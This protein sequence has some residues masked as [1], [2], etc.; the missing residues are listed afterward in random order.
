MNFFIA[1]LGLS[2]CSLAYIC[3]LEDVKVL[4]VPPFKFCMCVCTRC[5]WIYMWIHLYIHTHT[6]CIMHF[7]CIHVY[8]QLQKETIIFYLQIPNFSCIWNFLL[9]HVPQI[10]CAVRFQSHTAPLSIHSGI[11]SREIKDIKIVGWR[12]RNR[13]GDWKSVREQKQNK[14][15]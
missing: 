13:I 7:I 6:T 3:H 15:N 10:T 5:M 14:V 8:T 11:D 4:C 1:T 12:V 2:Y 9:W